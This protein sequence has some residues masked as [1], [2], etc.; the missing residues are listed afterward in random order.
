MTRLRT[1]L[2][3]A[4]AARAR[5]RDDREIA[6]ALAAAPTLESAHEIAALAARR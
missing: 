3:S 6:R 5:R 2:T 4:R 1:A